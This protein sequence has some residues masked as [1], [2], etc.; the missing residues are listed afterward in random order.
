MVHES[1]PVGY[2]YIEVPLLDKTKTLCPGFFSLEHRFYFSR[3]KIIEII[4]DA[5]YE[6]IS[7]IEHYQAEIYPV[8]GI[9]AAT[10]PLPNT[11]RAP[12][13]EYERTK[14]LLT[15]YFENEKAYW[16]NKYMQ[17]YDKLKAAENIYIWG[18]G[19]HTSLLFSTTPI[20][21]D[22]K[23]AGILD[24]AKSKWGLSYGK[25]VCM[26]PKKDNFSD[27]DVILISSYNSE[28]EIFN[29]IERTMSGSV[30]PIKFHSH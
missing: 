19:A 10:N 23:I 29:A 17:I 15:D 16:I 11:K 24:S 18:A 20:L 30:T 22:F 21:N 14:S 1:L 28:E 12:Q 25:W 7:I 9:L 8:I 26:Q 13:N 5:G 4:E 27:K 3:A 6:P 2:I